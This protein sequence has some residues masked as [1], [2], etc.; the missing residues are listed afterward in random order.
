[1]KALSSV[2]Q[3]I[4]DDMLERRP[5]LQTCVDGLLALHAAMVDTYDKGGKFIVCGNGGSF[6]DSIHI[7]GELCKSFER[8]RPVT[9]E[10]AEKLSQLP[11]GEEL[12]GNLEMGLSAIALRCNGSLKTAVENDIP[13]PNAA[14]AQEALALLKKEDVLLTIS[15]SGNA[16]NC[17]MALSVGKALGATTVT[18]T[19]RSGGKMAETADI[20]IVAPG[21]STHIIQEAHIVLYH[22][23]C[24]LIEAHYFPEPRE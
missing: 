6:A 1:M 23:M 21:D 13:L 5:D 20:A 4:L 24:A 22:T 11:C 12:A 16:K 18:L 7:V 2:E 9:P 14:F 17:L 8:K 10:I 3:K 15:T 19:G